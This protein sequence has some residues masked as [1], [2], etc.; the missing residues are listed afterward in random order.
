V[1]DCGNSGTGVRLLMGAV[2]AF[3]IEVTFT[4]DQSLRSRPMNRVLDPLR[5]M[6]VEAETSEGGRLPSTVRGAKVGGIHFVNAKASAQVKSAILLAGLGTDEPVEVLEPRPS[7]DHS[8]NMLRGFGADVEVTDT[9]DGRLVRLGANRK[10]VGTDVHVPGDPSSAAF[11]IVAALIVPGSEITIRNVMMNPLRTGLFATLMEMGGELEFANRRIVGGEEVADVTI[12]NQKLRGVEVPAE[13]APSMIDEYPILAVAAA[14]AEGRSVMHGLEE[15][16]VKESDRLAA[17]IAGL[18]ACGVDAR[19]EGD[20]LI[21]E[22]CGGPPPGGGDV[23]T[24]G[25]HRIAMSFLVLG[26]AA[27][28][29]VRVDEASMIGTSFPGFAELM[30]SIGASIETPK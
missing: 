13:R 10:L 7:R 30:R 22:G 9:P 28:Q 4:G 17:I 12:L 3:P 11:P 25:D 20:S 21:V 16:R 8:E 2:S 14:F 18:R 26:L 29:P 24:H 23:T 1:I 27:Q 5:D 6:G 15:L 19:D